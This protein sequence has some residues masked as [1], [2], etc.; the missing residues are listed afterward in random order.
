MTRHTV[1]RVWDIDRKE[2]ARVWGRHGK[3]AP[4]L[5]L[6]RRDADAWVA[7]ERRAAA[8][9]AVVECDLVPRDPFY[10]ELIER[11][12]EVKP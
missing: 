9:L 11:A 10:R 5:F 8:A 3:R 12:S 6:R 1:Y 7:S 4:D 2:W